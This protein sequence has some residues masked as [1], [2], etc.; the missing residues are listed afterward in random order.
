MP[1][2]WTSLTPT[3]R[4]STDWTRGGVQSGILLTRRP[5]PVS[6][7][8]TDS[9]FFSQLST[10]RKSTTQQGST[11]SATILGDSDIVL[12]ATGHAVPSSVVPDDDSGTYSPPSSAR[13]SERTPGPLST[14][15]TDASASS[16]V[17]S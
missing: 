4:Y 5:T 15:E 13:S 2:L 8:I 11:N 1:C 14:S 10:C 16:N 9:T 7:F 3:R 17:N 6:T 12:V